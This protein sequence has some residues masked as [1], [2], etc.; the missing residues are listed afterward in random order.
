MIYQN[1][2]NSNNSYFIIITYYKRKILHLLIMLLAGFNLEKE[3]VKGNI[4][5]FTKK[6]HFLLKNTDIFSYF[7]VKDF[8][9]QLILFIY[10]QI[11]RF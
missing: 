11:I 8:K 6:K 5:K 9:S 1:N 7:K 10:F 4:K 3:K 2:N